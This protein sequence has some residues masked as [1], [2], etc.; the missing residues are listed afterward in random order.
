MVRRALLRGRSAM[1]SITRPTLSILLAMRQRQVLMMWMRRCAPPIMLSAAGPGCLPLSGQAIFRPLL[2]ICRQM[3]RQPLPWPR[4][5]Q[6]N[7]AKS[8]LK[9]R[10]KL[11]VWLTGFSKWP[12]LH[13]VWLQR[14]RLAGLP[15]I[16]LSRAQGAALPP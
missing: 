2:T 14:N 9:A 13:R 15:L 4:N 11:I 7:M 12:A 16:R 10:W 5:S 1:L 8:C 3:R 6:P